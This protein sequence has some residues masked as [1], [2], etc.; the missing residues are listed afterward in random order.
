[1]STYLL[2][3]A[4]SRTSARPLGIYSVC[5]AHPWVL[6]AAMRRHLTASGP[7]LIEATCNQVNQFGGY[8]GMQPGDFREL[9][10]TIARKVGFPTDRILLGGDHLGPYPWQHLPAEVAMQHAC[11][12]VSLFVRQGYGKIHLDASMPCADDPHPLPDHII[13]ERAARL[14]AAAEAAAEKIS[15]VYIIGTEVPTPGGAL[16]DEK[17]AVTPP[18]A[19]NEALELHR[20]AFAAAGLE[21]AWPRVI[22]LVV[23]P[24]VEFGHDS[25]HDYEPS[26]AANLCA[27]LAQHPGLVFEAHS[28]DYQL[29]QALSALVRDGFAI[30]KVGP[31]L[32]YAMRQALFA[33]AQVEE[34]CV[35]SSQQSHLRA[36]LEDVMLQHPTQWQKH[37]PGTP[38]EQRRLRV[39]SYSDR[40]RYYW[41]NPAVQQAV[42][43][44]IQNLDKTGIP[45]TM[46]SDYL[47]AQYSKI[48]NGALRNQ[49]LALVLDAIGD[50]LQPYIGA[51]QQG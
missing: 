49:P 38:D 20:R 6:E 47:P 30:L 9:V 11:T 23:Q 21:A 37:Y 51:C 33:L 43:T 13:A 35:P 34:E 12:M 7:L 44:L 39:H 16:E 19:A 41:T 22:A 42:D 17:L 27:L 31:G 14:C 18:E 46:L 15:P 3:L 24:G 26:K 5:S 36:C 29:P 50:A 8:T 28:T 2:Q 48:R 40:I 4:N 10:H 25:I 45:E 32:T 1:M